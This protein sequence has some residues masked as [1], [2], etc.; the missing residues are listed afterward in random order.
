MT[1]TP[2]TR[3]STRWRASASRRR[4]PTS[5]GRPSCPVD[6]GE[7][8]A[9]QGWTSRG[10]TRSSTRRTRCARTPCSQVAGL[11]ERALFVGDPGQLDPLAACGA[12]SS[13]RAWPT[14]RRPRA[15]TTLLA[16]NPGLPQ[17]RLPGLLAAPGAR[18]LPAW[19]PDA[20]YPYTPFRSG[21]GPRRPELAFGGAGGRRRPGP[22]DRRGGGAPA[23]ACW[24]SRPGT[25]RAPTPRRCGRC[26]AVVR[27]LLDR[28]GPRRPPS[29]PRPRHRSP[30]PASPWAPRTGTRRRAVRAALAD[31]GVTEVTVD[32]ANR[33]QGREYDVTRRPAPAL[34]PP[35]RHRL[36]P[37]DR[38]ACASWPPRH[39]HACIV[40]CREGVDDLLDDYPSTEPVQLERWHRRSSSTSW[41][42]NHAVL[43]HLAEHRVAWRHG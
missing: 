31:L 33:L 20:F 22:G 13:G 28:G 1:P 8:G 42:A 17:H 43:A 40:V 25:P 10:G 37:G 26:A 9:R 29:A 16:H 11:F 6:G 14:T 30:P 36:P 32:T 23:G 12:A 3:R 34:R 5:P 38:P 21:T 24:S 41:E 27:R 15:V 18:R 19:S 7:V 4:P 39:R 2:T 35:R